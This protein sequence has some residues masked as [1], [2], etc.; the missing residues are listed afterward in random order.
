VEVS[1]TAVA[2]WTNKTYSHASTGHEHAVSSVL[3]TD[4]NNTQHTDT[5]TCDANGYMTCRIEGGATYIQEN[6]AEERI[7]VVSLYDSGTC[8]AHDAVATK[9]W[10]S[11]MLGTEKK[12]NQHIQPIMVLY[13][14]TISMGQ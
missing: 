10:P 6:K 3:V 1:A 4:K 9:T 12:E 11:P 14:P 13:Q 7:S 5:Y 2:G 8:N